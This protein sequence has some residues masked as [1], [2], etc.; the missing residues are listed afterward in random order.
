MAQLREVKKSL[1]QYDIKDIASIR[2][3]ESVIMDRNLLLFHPNNKLD[4]DQLS[5]ALGPSDRGSHADAKSS[6]N[7]KQTSGRKQV[8]KML[9]VVLDS[10]EKSMLHVIR[11][12]KAYPSV[13]ALY[14]SAVYRD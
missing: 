6:R 12:S 11:I 10:Q 7:V 2:R 5:S 4:K 13:K 1:P 3:R 8:S 9:S 14:N